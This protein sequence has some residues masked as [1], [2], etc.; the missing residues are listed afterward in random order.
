MIEK[1]EH[2]GLVS[3]MQSNGSREILVQERN[4]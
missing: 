3:A 2:N 4:E 1:M